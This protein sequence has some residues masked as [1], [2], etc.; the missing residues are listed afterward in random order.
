MHE[1]HKLKHIKIV[2]LVIFHKDLY[3]AMETKNL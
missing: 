3:S 2:L 1:L